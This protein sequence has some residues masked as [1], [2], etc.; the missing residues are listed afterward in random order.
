MLFPE[1][2]VPAGPRESFLGLDSNHAKGPAVGLLADF[3]SQK[4]IAPRPRDG[5][6]PTVHQGQ[7]G[8]PV[9]VCSSD[10]AGF[11]WWVP[12]SGVGICSA[13]GT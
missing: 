11:L 12:R 9:G 13:S 1:R 6:W 5:G 8:G 3:Q 2:R 10:S 4:H 7:L